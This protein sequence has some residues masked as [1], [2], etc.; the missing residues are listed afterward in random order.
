M[1]R[2]SKTHLATVLVALAPGVAA[3]QNPAE[4]LRSIEPAARSADPGFRG[5]SPARGEQLFKSTHG[6]DWS[7]ASCHT[8]DPRAQGRHAKTGKG[9]AP[10]APAANA[11]R[12][13]EPAKIEKWF[14]RNCNDVLNRACTPQEKGDVV[15]WLTS[16]RR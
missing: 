5:F 3:A 15:T 12:F 16:L 1:F 9:I 8:V 4:Y 6:G 14:K 7:C 13:N 2:L 10:L 11:E